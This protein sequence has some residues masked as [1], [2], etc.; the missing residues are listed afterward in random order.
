MG[1][2]AEIVLTVGCAEITSATVI[3]RSDTVGF[4]AVIV[5]PERSTETV[6]GASIVFSF[7]VSLRN[8]VINKSTSPEWVCPRANS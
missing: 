2:G 1:A 5:H 3:F 7:A 8:S 6:F 4:G